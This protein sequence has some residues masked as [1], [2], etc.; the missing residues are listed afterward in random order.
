MNTNFNKIILFNIV[1]LLS[2][3][4]LFYNTNNK[5]KTPIIL[6]TIF[7]LYI[8]NEYPL[9]KYNETFTN[10]PIHYKMGSYDNLKL[11]P[12]GCSNW[13][14]PPACKKLYKWDTVYTPQGT[15]FPLNPKLSK[16]GT[17]NGPS[18]DGTKETP[19]DM[20]M[21]AYNQ[22]SPECCPSTYSTDRGC[23][24]TTKQQR[25]FINSRGNNRNYYHSSGIS[26]I[27]A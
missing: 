5:L 2:L 16:Q 17:N 25:E 1:I 14:H 21:F 22:S 26:Y 8:L 3:V 6:L 12:E 15:P 19:N 23:V 20:F 11:K 7:I 24:C 27:D 10:A 4:C 9:K 13:R 18:V